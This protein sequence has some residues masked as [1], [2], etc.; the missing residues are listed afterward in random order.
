MVATPRTR[1]SY[2]LRSTSQSS[3]CSLPRNQPHH[4]TR[5]FLT[6]VAWASHVLRLSSG[7]AVI[8]RTRLLE[9]GFLWRMRQNLKKQ[10]AAEVGRYFSGA[11]VEARLKAWSQVPCAI[12][13][14]TALDR[15]VAIKVA[16]ERFSAR[17][18]LVLYNADQAVWAVPAVNATPAP[19]SCPTAS[20]P[21]ST[22]RADS[23]RTRSQA[24]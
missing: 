9:L 11:V 12:Q 4:F 20:R 1:L 15:T 2:G 3:V 18:R 14:L 23:R 13:W 5:P 10:Q 7:H 16:Q 17:S 8:R 19:V 21:A 24:T 22:G 6:C